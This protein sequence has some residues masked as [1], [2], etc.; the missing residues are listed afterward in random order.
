MT[1]TDD[2]QAHLPL[3]GVWAGEGKGNKRETNK[4][5]NKQKTAATICG[6][7]LIY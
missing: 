2:P 3:K 7:K 5:T 6:G 1:G 4:Q